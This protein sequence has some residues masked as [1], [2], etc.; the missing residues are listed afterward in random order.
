M[1]I[2]PNGIAIVKAFEGCHK[3]VRGRPGYFTTYYDP[4]VLTIGWGHTN[5]HPPKFKA[6]DVWSQAACDA[7]LAGDMVIFEKHVAKHAKVPLKQHEYD[8]LVSWSYNTGG[9][10]HAT[11]W[12]KLNAGDKAAI[13]GELAKWNKDNGKVVNGLVRRRKSEGQLFAGDIK[14][15]LK[16]AQATPTKAATI[17]AG[18]AVATGTV[19]AAASGDWSVALFVLGG[20]LLVAAIAFIIIKN[21]RK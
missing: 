21:K 13:P 2:G 20:A 4:H 5:H 7:V 12:K 3:A 9:P 1:K 11:L 19:A 15:A 14:G 10:S 17:A 16:T 8:A 18:T 6:G